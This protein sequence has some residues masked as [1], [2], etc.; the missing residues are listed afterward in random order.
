M[1][2]D[3]VKFWV[4][5]IVFQVCFGLAVFAVTRAHYMQPATADSAAQRAS[6]SHSELQS[7]A[8]VQPLTSLGPGDLTQFVQTGSNLPSSGG[9]STTQDPLELS[10]LASQAFSNQQYD[11]A[12]NY[13]QRLAALEPDS[14]DLINEIGLTLHYLGRSTEAVQKLKEGVAKNPKHQRIQL[15]LGFVYSQMG[16]FKDARS[17]LTA[18]SQL[19]TD[20]GI[21]QS[22][23]DML[24]KLPQ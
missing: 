19:G 8:P 17:A 9:A 12:L 6:A 2:R 3:D 24:K 22:A 23:L 10:R 20:A 11:A 4:S 13:Y 16:N 14:V 1:N 15:T 7:A 5:M 21:K 18:A